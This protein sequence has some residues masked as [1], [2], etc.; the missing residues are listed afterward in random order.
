MS[1]AFDRDKLHYPSTKYLGIK[2]RDRDPPST[3]PCY[4]LVG[5]LRLRL[6]MPRF[7]IDLRSHF[8]TSEDPDGLDLPD[9]ATAHAEALK[10][11]T[12]LLPGCS[13]VPPHYCREI[14]VDILGEDFR[15]LLTIRYPDI[16]AKAP[17]ADDLPDRE[18]P[19][20]G[21]Q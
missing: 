16:V 1:W 4:H 13:N 3:L 9:F 18:P 10:I 21:H 2:S 7:Y 12:A 5:F 11:V 8:G 19:P 20:F 6:A 17:L 14:A 15:P